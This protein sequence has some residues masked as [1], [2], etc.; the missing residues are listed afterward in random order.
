MAIS[1]TFPRPKLV[2]TLN[3]TVPITATI[4]EDTVN[5]NYAVD[6]KYTVTKDDTTTDTKVLKRIKITPVISGTTVRLDLQEL[7][8]A[9]TAPNAPTDAQASVT[10][11]VIR[12]V[13]MDLDTFLTAVGDARKNS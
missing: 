8:F 9:G 7:T 11:E 5:N 12:G 13:T 10:G 3:E 6:I 2:T 4:T 1:L